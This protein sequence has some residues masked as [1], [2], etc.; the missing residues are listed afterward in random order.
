[1][2]RRQFLKWALWAGA[3]GLV[4]QYGLLATELTRGGRTVGRTTGAP[5][6]AVPTVCRLCPAR[7]GVLAFLENGVLVK[8]E[9]N[10]KDPNARGGICAKGL[11]GVQLLLQPDRLL[12]PLRRVGPRGSG[13]WEAVG[14]DDVLNELSS[15]LAQIR[16][17]DS[18]RFVFL[19]GPPSQSPDALTLRFLRAFGRPT[20]SEAR[21]LQ[22]ANR[23]QALSLTWGADSYVP[24]LA[25]T[26]YILNF[27]AN[28]YESHEMYVPLVRRLIEGRRSGAKLVTFDPRLSRTA[29]QSDEWFPVRSGTDAAVALAMANVITQLGLYDR[30]YFEK[31]SNWPPEGLAEHLRPYTPEWAEGFSGIAATHIR[32]IAV[33]FATTHPA[34]VLT[35]GSLSQHANGLQNERAVFLLAALTGNVERRGGLCLPRRYEFADPK[36]YLS[37]A[38]DLLPPQEMFVQI[39]RGE[40]S[41]QLL[42]IDRANPAFDQPEPKS[43]QEILR[44]ERK[45]PF[46]VVSDSFQTE[47]ADLADLVLPATTF[48]ES[49]ELHSPPGYDIVPFVALQQPAIP[50]LG[51]A[52][53]VPEVLL[54]LAK[55]MGGDLG[56]FFPFG[57]TKEY[58]KQQVEAVA[59]LSAEGGLEYLSEA[60]IWV[61]ATHPD[62]GREFA[63]DSKRLEIF[64]SILSLR[65]Q[66]A[67]PVYLALTEQEQLEADE[68]LLIVYQSAVQD[69]GVTP[70]LWWLL[71]IEHSNSLWINAGMAKRLGI[72]EGDWVEV[73]SPVGQIRVRAFPTE[74]I[75][76]Q[77][78]AIH[79]DLGHWG[80][81]RLAQGGAFRSQDPNTSLIWW[82]E[83]GTHVQP[84]VAIRSDSAGGGQAWQDTVVRVVKSRGG[85]S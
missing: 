32:R 2:T 81:G 15:R 14:W 21:L 63:T 19:S 39:S 10:P 34:L 58:V 64:S 67:L 73:S 71:E 25:H 54:E 70:L 75:H 1:M 46:L 42:W 52:R 69:G 78:V 22:V 53:A 33:E 40:I 18:K 47:T 8:I 37:G 41:P 35:G 77:T 4:S 31:N 38:T 12:R 50:P 65:K 79:G 48:L 29:G 23:T 30:E 61:A 76:P 7:C 72:H 66:P 26:K 16:S 85:I 43:V 83:A 9:G 13:R 3:A 6:I 51:E 84:L 28:P 80:L 27:G 20:V 55:R 68:F 24:D 62:Y 36:P 57:S 11:A 45:V 17:Q 49:W 56:S 60:G 44:D 74:G 59:E 82:N 5:R